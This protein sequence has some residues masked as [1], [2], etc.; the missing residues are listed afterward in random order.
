MRLLPARSN[1]RPSNTLSMELAL[2][3][4]LRPIRRLLRIRRRRWF[5]AYQR[6]CRVAGFCARVLFRAR[7]K[8]SRGQSEAI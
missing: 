6:Q 7:V 3:G 5:D 4:A 1:A 2:T 8:P